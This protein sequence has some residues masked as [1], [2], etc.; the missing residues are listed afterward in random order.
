[1]GL[2]LCVFFLCFYPLHCTCS[3]ILVSLFAHF[4]KTEGEKSENWMVGEVD[5]RD[6]GGETMIRIYSIKI[7]K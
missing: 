6:E 7:F 4:F 3:S 2:L 5:V 1:M